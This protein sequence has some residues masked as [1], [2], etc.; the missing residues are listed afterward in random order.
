MYVTCAGTEGE[1]CA[2]DVRRGVAEDNKSQVA[3]GRLDKGGTIRVGHTAMAPMLSADG[4]T[5]YVC[6]RFDN[7]V[8][9]IDL[10]RAESKTGAPKANGKNIGEV[11]LA[12][13]KEI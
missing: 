12:G 2:V 11:N 1:V 5:L 8:S 13:A 7:D 4:K 10:V 3:Y 9:V 6:N